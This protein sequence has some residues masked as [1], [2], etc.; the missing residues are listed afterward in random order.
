[1]CNEYYGRAGGGGAP[2]LRVQQ[3]PAI[4]RGLLMG[5]VPLYPSSIAWSIALGLKGKAS[6]L[7]P[8]VPFSFLT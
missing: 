4:W 5:G 8:L 2:A 7:F 3:N 6:P 1:M